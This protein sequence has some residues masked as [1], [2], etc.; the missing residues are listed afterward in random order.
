MVDSIVVFLI[1]LLSLFLQA[2]PH[3]IALWVGRIIG[4]IFSKIYQ[5]RRVAYANLKAAF[6]NQFTA[7]DRKKIIER[8]FLNLA[9]TVIEVLR[10]PKLNMDYFDRYVSV[11]GRERYEA[12]AR[13]N[14]AT[15][16]ITAH[17]GNWEL[18]Q[19][20]SALVGK[21]LHFLV[22]QQNHI[23]DLLNELRSSRG[24]IAIHRGKAVRRLIRVLRD[25]GMVG[26]LGDFSGGREG[27][28]VQFFGRKT[29]APSGIFQIA[30]RTHAA[31]LP[32]FMVRLDCGPYHQVFL[33]EVFPLAKAKDGSVDMPGSVQNYYHLLE[34]WIRKYPDQWFWMYRR[35]KYCFTK[36]ILILKDDRAGHNNQSEAIAQEFKR[37]EKILGDPYEFKFKTVQVQFKSK[38]HQKLFY[39]F[40]FFFLPFAQGRLGV[41]KFFLTPEC[42]R[43]LEQQFADFIIST[44]SSL[45]PL[46]LLLKKENLAR[47]IV[48]MKPSAP[49]SLSQFD[50]SILPMHDRVA[51]ESNRVVRT[52][53][54]PN[55][56]EPELLEKAGAKL[57]DHI[58]PRSNGSKRLSIFIGGSSKS[59]RFDLNEFQ[60]WASELKT[61]SEKS[62]Y[63]LL[64]TTSRRTDESAA[65]ILK[66]EF[67][68]YPSTKLLVIANEANLDQVTYGMLAHCDIA[69]VTEDS[70]SMISE[71]V[72]AGKQVV[73][74]QLGNGKLPK[75]HSRFH[76]LLEENKLIYM[77][78]A[79]N[80]YS[81]LSS[82]NGTAAS[83]IM[84]DQA[85]NIQ[86]ALR[87]M[88]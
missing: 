88:L 13:G 42:T 14:Q 5:R 47:S 61:C 12:L 76:Q 25:G 19:I 39:L 17:F 84:R 66:T 30:E 79:A 4:I 55:P 34:K 10:F 37:L 40:T 41:F 83:E 58:S 38:I 8:H 54:T 15:V 21:P 7:K 33:E 20:L 69:V 23:N 27:I 62:N 56:V 67:S 9:Q 51:K 81:K 50:L 71:A 72:A 44:G 77:A 16:L 65:Q 36:H 3:R 86:K 64:I 82:V 68:A 26:I 35:W 57:S 63:E 22:R 85:Q 48:V 28:P 70:V 32:C 31:I 75:K 18:S 53:V 78:N 80:F 11:S 1:R 24:S 46:N 43:M 74:L 29:T 87:K 2:L 52:L 49:Y 73:V 59:Y 45:V 6:E 60:K